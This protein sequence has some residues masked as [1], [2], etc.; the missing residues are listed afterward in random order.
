MTKVVEQ[1]QNILQERFQPKILEVIDESD[2]HIGHAG[3]DGLGESHFKVVIKAADF[4]GQSRITCHRMIYD[5]L[6]VL[7]KQR[8]HA[9]TIE[10]KK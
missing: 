8:V 10:I 3:H 4:E 9:L 7:I 1:M 6:D 5:A 2:H